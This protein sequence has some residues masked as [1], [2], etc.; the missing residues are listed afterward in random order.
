MLVCALS[1]PLMAATNRF[2]IYNA[3]PSVGER[4]F[5][6][7]S[8]SESLLARQFSFE[9]SNTFAYRPLDLIDTSG[10][11]SRNVVNYYVNETLAVG[12]GIT[13][14]WQIGAEGAFFSTASFEDPAT[15]VSPG[16]EHVSDVGDLRF[17]TKFQ[18]LDHYRY[19]VGLAVEPFITAPVGNESHFLANTG[20]AGGLNAIVDAWLSK[21][22]LIAADLGAEF[23]Q[24]RVQASNIDFRNRFLAGIGLY[25][26]LI[27]N[28]STFAEAHAATSFGKFFS[29]KPTS[30]LDFLVGGRKEF[31]DT[32]VSLEAGAGTCMVCGGGAAR[33]SCFLNVSYEFQN[34]GIREKGALDREHRR[35]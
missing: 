6:I 32:G 5:F 29:D 14:W 17:T 35:R 27:Q 16:S 11:V 13:D 10:A 34:E 7:L 1:R 22:F 21:R 19:P 18:I 20:V 4:H 23:R 9:L 31:G 24:D 25:A 12:L 28:F 30:P 2:S 3:W 8:S 26:D 33:V 15:V